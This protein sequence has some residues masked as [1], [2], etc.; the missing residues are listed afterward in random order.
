MSAGEQEELPEPKK[1][2][3]DGAEAEV[4]EDE[5]FDSYGDLS[6]HRLMLMDKPRMEAYV[7]AIERNRSFIEGKVCMDVGT[8]TGFLAMMCA[9]LGGAK[10]VHAVEACPKIAAVA[11][12][13]VARNGLTDRVTVHSKPVEK[14]TREDLGLPGGDAGAANSE[15]VVDV[16]VSEWMG[17][18]LVH[19]SMVESVLYARDRFLRPGGLLLPSSCRLFAAPLDLRQFHREKVSYFEDDT[20]FGLSGFGQHFSGLGEGGAVVAASEFF[21][22]EPNVELGLSESELLCEGKCFREIDLTKVSVEELQAIDSGELQ[23]STSKPGLFG[24]VGIW[25][26]CTFEIRGGGS[27]SSGSQAVPQVV[28]CTAPRSE[29]T[30]WKQT[31]VF[32]VGEEGPIFAE[33]PSGEDISFSL[34]LEQSDE[35]PRHYNISLST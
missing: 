29:M 2:R 1:R 11:R 8:G 17:F 4:E 31:I 5:Y 19:E 13:L 9:K 28:L 18:Y 6:V 27:S 20:F 16:L 12:S 10:H 30:H 34:L 26:D 14:L 22:G 35:N 3:L 21:S 15:A 33:V 23:F 25:F 7:R 32:L 24:G